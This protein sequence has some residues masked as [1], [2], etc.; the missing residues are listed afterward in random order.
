[1]L[2]VSAFCGLLLLFM[3][4]AVYDCNH[5]RGY[6]GSITSI[7]TKTRIL[8]HHNKIPAILIWRVEI[9]AQEQQIE[10]EMNPSIFWVQIST[11][12]VKFSVRLTNWHKLF[13]EIFINQPYGIWRLGCWVLILWW[14]WHWCLAWT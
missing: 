11:L 12:F 7:W 6:N 13:N 5:S 9:V 2:F 8:Y 3:T 14:L 4:L 1:M 10:K